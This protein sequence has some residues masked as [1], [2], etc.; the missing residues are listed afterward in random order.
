[1]SATREQIIGMS[2]DRHMSVSAGAGSGKTRVLV[3]RFIEI[4]DQNP[5]IE[6]KSIVAITFTRKAAAEM[7]KRIVETVEKKLDD[8]MNAD[9]PDPLLISKWDSIRQKLPAAR[10]S[11]IHSFC[12]AIIRDYPIEAEIPPNFSELSKGE[13][14]SLRISCAEKT[15]EDYLQDSD[16]KPR[17]QKLFDIYTKSK[18]LSE[19]SAFLSFPIETVNS[20]EQLQYK[21]AKELLD[22]ACNS[23]I[24]PLAK[25][26]YSLFEILRIFP[27]NHEDSINNALHSIDGLYKQTV[28]SHQ[29]ILIFD[30]II[31][32]IEDI[33]SKYLTKEH[34]ISKKLYKLFSQECIEAYISFMISYPDFFSTITI[35][36]DSLA[37]G[38]PLAEINA[39]EDSRF[40]SEIG[41]KAARLFHEIKKQDSILEADDLQTL[42][43]QVL[44]QEIVAKKVRRTLNFLM[45]DEFQD[46]NYHQY[47]L[48]KS[49]VTALQSNP[50]DT[51][52]V[53]F[54]IVGDS[55]QSIYGFRSADVR[56]FEEAGE[57]I[58]KANLK[59]GKTDSF[60]ST[61]FSTE[62]EQ[63]GLLQLHVTFRLMP[64]I[65]GFVNLICKAIMPQKAKGYEVG[66]EPM[67][68]GRGIHTL[69]EKKDIGSITAI[70][71]QAPPK[72]EIS[73]DPIEAELVAKKVKQIV[74]DQSLLVWDITIEKDEYGN[75]SEQHIQRQAI[76]SDI[77]I[78]FSRRT[79]LNALI[80]AFKAEDIPYFINGGFGFYTSPEITDFRSYISFL[81]S[82]A[83]D[84]ACAA[85]LVSP[86]FSI[87]DSILL[88][89]KQ[90]KSNSLWESFLLLAEHIQKEHSHYIFIQR[91]S[92]ILQRIISLSSRLSLPIL[93]RTM[94]EESAWLQTISYMDNSVQM[95]A[96]AEKLI[97]L[98]RTFENKGFKG[99][100]D[101]SEELEL[102]SQDDKEEAAFIPHQENA[103][104]CMTIHSAKGL[105]F[106]IVLIYDTNA[107]I[108]TSPSHHVHL[109]SDLGLTNKLLKTFKSVGSNEFS[110]S[111]ME[112][113]VKQEN[114]NKE[115]A[116]KKRLLYVALTRAKDHLLFSGTISHDGK[117]AAHS[118]LSLIT[119]GCPF[120]LDNI[121]S[122]QNISSH[123][124]E[125]IIIYKNSVQEEAAV[126]I[127]FSLECIIENIHKEIIVETKHAEYGELLFN[128]VKTEFNNEVYSA[129]QIITA[130]NK[131][132]EYIRQYVYGFPQRNDSSF[133]SL[134]DEYHDDIHGAK[135]GILIHNMM[136]HINEWM[137]ADGEVELTQFLQ[138]AQS[139]LHKEYIYDDSLIL[140][141]LK[142]ECIAVVQT[143]L[144]RNNTLHIQKAKFEHTLTIPFLNDF[145]ITIFDILIENDK[146]DMEIW[147]WKTNKC[148]LDSDMDLLS[149]YYT[150]QM[151]IY[152]YMCSLLYP[153]Q[154]IFRARLLFTRMA[155]P[156]AEDEMWSRTITR[157]KQDIQK[158][159]QELIEDIN[160]VR[161]LY[162]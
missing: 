148:T 82:P 131:P 104:Q 63:M 55:K 156:D 85:L 72:G 29:D 125:N 121:M 79:K 65:V 76:W 28:F 27:D 111:I 40:I 97:E 73:N 126:H 147:D 26:L 32:T 139:V 2:F 34:H 89:A 20:L 44:Q 80:A 142:N 24:L 138:I 133:S 83:N 38:F 52:H 68:A 145:L 162:I 112:T 127:P 137:N 140:E 1:M 129:T 90:Y 17:I 153:N 41:I 13:A 11:T 157:N 61:D 161:E 36:K 60:P 118:L 128:R 110:D 114:R 87:K 101:F 14:L 98:A 10:I 69:I 149:D 33:S 50:N 37:C 143:K 135:A 42:A 8:I 77:A 96:N 64:A 19:I 12:S 48:A 59:A 99:L 30:A 115:I 70:I 39:I 103:V 53:N 92:T 51:H 22:I 120:L 102:L 116:E 5:G 94:I 67:I 136:E 109:S 158:I 45:I 113:I 130:K 81:H 154:E 88:E 57:D 122:E 4:L 91:A 152:L 35:I 9:Y 105:E 141:R 16:L 159:Y 7:H 78:L 124:Q 21:P 144:L 84:I 146:G 132:S 71:T 155:K 49:I 95:K 93:I 58:K 15:L 107:G 25:P 160:V 18:L 100:Y 31:K 119:E 46:T 74:L 75:Q 106:P 62:Q 150:K 108:N 134:F 43:L 56:V 117:I 151:E 6:I 23:I 66:F 123:I 3:Q 54:Y 47:S 86:F